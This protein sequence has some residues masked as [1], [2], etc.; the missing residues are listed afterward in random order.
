MRSAPG[1]AGAAGGH[2]TDALFDGDLSDDSSSSSSSHGVPGAAGWGL[3]AESPMTSASD[4]GGAAGGAAAG[5][6]AAAAASA[7]WEAAG[8]HSTSLSDS[9]SDSH[10]FSSLGPGSDSDSFST[11]WEG[12]AGFGAGGWM[13]G[14]STSDPLSSGDDD[15]LGAPAQTASRH[16]GGSDFG[17]ESD[18]TEDS[19]SHSYSGEPAGPPGSEPLGAPYAG[20]ARAAPAAP[21]AWGAAG[22]GAWHGVPNWATGMPPD[23]ADDQSGAA[24][25]PQP[26]SHS[27]QGAAAAHAGP[28]A[29]PAPWA[30]QQADASAVAQAVEQGHTRRIESWFDLEALLRTDA[31]EFPARPEIMDPASLWGLYRES[32]KVTRRKRK[33]LTMDLW[34]NSGGKAGAT[35]SP[36]GML[37]SNVRICRRYGTIKRGSPD[38]PRLKFLEYSLCEGDE[39]RPQLTEELRQRRLFQVVPGGKQRARGGGGGAGAAEQSQK[40]PRA[41]SQAKER[42]RYDG[43]GAAAAATDSSGELST[44][45]IF[46]LI[47]NNRRPGFSALPERPRNVGGSWQRLYAEDRRTAILKRQSMIKQNMANESQPDRWKNAGGKNCKVFLQIPGMD[48]RILRRRG[49]VIRPGMPSLKYDQFSIVDAEGNEQGEDTLYVLYE[50][51]QVEN[52][53]AAFMPMP[54]QAGLKRRR[55]EDPD[56]DDLDEGG[57]RQLPG[58]KLPAAAAFVALTLVGVSLLGRMRSPADGQPP[59]SAFRCDLMHDDLP[60]ISP[61]S[62]RYFDQHC[63]DTSAGVDQNVLVDECR[64]ASGAA[65]E[66]SWLPVNGLD[67]NHVAVVAHIDTRSGR[68]TR[69]PHYIANLRHRSGAVE[70][71]TLTIG[72]QT[73]EGFNAYLSHVPVLGAGESTGGG[74][75]R[76]LGALAQQGLEVAW[77]GET[78]PCGRAG[79]TLLGNTHWLKASEH[80][81]FTSVDLSAGRFKTSD[82]TIVLTLACKEQGFCWQTAGGNVAYSV[83]NDRVLVY[84][85]APAISFGSGP[86]QADSSQ[87]NAWGWRVNWFGTEETRRGGQSDLVEASKFRSV[88]YSLDIDTA[89]AGFT[90]TPEYFFSPTVTLESSTVSECVRMGQTTCTTPRYPDYVKSDSERAKFSDEKCGI[91]TG[92]PVAGG[93]PT[94]C[95]SYALDLGCLNP[96]GGGAPIC[97]RPVVNCTFN[98]APAINTDMSCPG[99]DSTFT[100]TGV[101]ASASGAQRLGVTL[102]TYH[103]AASQLPWLEEGGP[104]RYESAFAESVAWMGWTAPIQLD[105]NGNWVGGAGHTNEREIASTP[106]VFAVKWIAFPAESDRHALQCQQQSAR[107]PTTQHLAAD[108]SSCADILRQNPERKGQDGVYLIDVSPRQGGYSDA[109]DLGAASTFPVYCDMTREDGGWSLVYKIAGSSGMASSG[110]VNRDRLARSA[111][112]G[113][114]QWG[115]L[116][117]GAIRPLCTEQYRVVQRGGGDRT[118]SSLFCSFVDVDEYCDSCVNT[119]KAC[120]TS[121]HAQAD[122][123]YLKDRF[124]AGLSR[125]FSTWPNPYGSAAAAVGLTVVQVGFDESDEGDCP[126]GCTNAYDDRHRG[127]NATCETRAKREGCGNLLGQCDE[128]CHAAT[129]GTCNDNFK[130]VG[131]RGSPSCYGCCAGADRTGKR[132]KTYIW[133]G[134][135]PVAR[136]WFFQNET[137]AALPPPYCPDETA[138]DACSYLGGC[139]TQVWCR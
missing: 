52:P 28:M 88:K 64:V 136:N 47:Q 110:A 49:K 93:T 118:P 39:A 32:P 123:K 41:A 120:S 106:L 92:F 5:G 8:D 44:L 4:S 23:A 20:A 37:A 54:T 10:S 56:E 119:R 131:R 85:F 129:C 9:D 134:G 58:G 117:D 73:P 13:S 31:Y 133:K 65:K 122:Y 121:Y 127:S 91:A 75:R 101:S 128:L 102:S 114:E 86:G 14:D 104:D 132:D 125:G 113:S 63:C 61:S 70:G 138:I 74:L 29:L 12:A 55:D 21:A 43:G 50:S 17:L 3:A 16:V 109:R 126:S 30:G 6:A 34:S 42:Q 45:H 69:T 48:S 2:W 53:A 68:F 108:G 99:L 116:A 95:K 135:A 111:D 35:L 103:P 83:T 107:I 77:A 66:L 15:V 79:S 87:L 57:K 22:D 25:Q 60:F 82:P 137:T 96:K 98:L 11:S 94:Q 130:Q 71:V 46:N 81:V 26:W 18:P 51:G 124:D 115:K 97:M 112:I 76:R 80:A 89:A 67:G 19:S 38:L 72:A 90:E 27:P 7:P 36:E 24:A 40:R 62:Q 33:G 78:T 100:G 1:A 105:S 59:T 139:H 84:V